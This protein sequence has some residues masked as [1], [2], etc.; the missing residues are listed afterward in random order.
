MTKNKLLD[1][2]LILVA[3]I[4]VGIMVF[5]LVGLSYVIGY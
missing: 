1:W 4:H 2:S 3:L 5:M